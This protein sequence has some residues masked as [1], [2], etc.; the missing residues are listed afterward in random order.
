MSRPQPIPRPLEEQRI[1][2][3]MRAFIEVKIS[4]LTIQQIIIED[5]TKFKPSYKTQ[6]ALD[7]DAQL[8]TAMKML[9]ALMKRKNVPDVG[10][11]SDQELK[12]MRIT[13]G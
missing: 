6:I 4:S 8:T 10:R 1:I 11:Y 12:D 7:V 2:E 5:T 13:E 3:N 9:K